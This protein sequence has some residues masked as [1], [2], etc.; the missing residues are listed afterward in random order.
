MTYTG[1][2][3]NVEFT[4]RRENG[5]WKYGIN[6]ESFGQYAEHDHAIHAPIQHID[7]RLFEAAQ[8]RAQ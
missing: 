5:A 3:R 1:S 2:H 8:S 4:V 7:R 6:K